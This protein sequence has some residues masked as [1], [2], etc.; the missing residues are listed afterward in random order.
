MTCVK[1]ER[2]GERRRGFHHGGHG[3]VLPLPWERAGVRVPF[4]LFSVPSVPSVL[5]YPRPKARQGNYWHASHSGLSMEQNF[6]AASADPSPAPM[7]EA[8]RPPWAGTA[9][10]SPPL[11]VDFSALVA[12]SVRR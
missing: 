3:E 8:P 4:S 12:A 1:A 9:F 6:P 5:N 10:N 2:G 7:P 11:P